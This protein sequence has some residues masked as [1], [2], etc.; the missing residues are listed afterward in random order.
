MEREKINLRTEF[1]KIAAAEVGNM[2]M[3]PNRSPRI[4]QYRD[5]TAL[6]RNGLADSSW[7]WCSAYVCWVVR[8]YLTKYSPELLTHRMKSARAND[9]ETWKFP[10]VRIMNLSES[11]ARAGDIITFEFDGDPTAEHVG[12]VAEDQDKSTSNILTIEGNTKPGSMAR[13]GGGRTDGVYEMS[14]APRLVRKLVRFI[15]PNV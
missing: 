14:R 8:E 2:E 1:V 15:N 6:G 5:A 11:R 7:F 13:D 12:I 3:T 4:L 10:G 9:W